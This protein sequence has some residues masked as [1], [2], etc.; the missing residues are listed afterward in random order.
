MF[1]RKAFTLI[2]SLLS[3]AV[4]S[5]T[6]SIFLNA[7]QLLKD[8]HHD[9][10]DRQNFLGLMELR[11]IIAMG[12]TFSIHHD[13]L[14]MDYQADESCFYLSHQKLIQSP[15]TIIYMIDLEDLYF[16]RDEG[17]LY[18]NYLLNDV[19]YVYWIGLLK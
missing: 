18:L 12:H 9:S 13:E 5:I 14:C 2:E 17:S 8:I 3:L 10:V 11:R 6:L 19:E 16:S 4:V 1:N 7:Y 15:G